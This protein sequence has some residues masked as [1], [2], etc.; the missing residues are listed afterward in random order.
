MLSLPDAE[1]FRLAGVTPRGPIASRSLRLF[2]RGRR[3]PDAGKDRDQAQHQIS[4]RCRFRAIITLFL[5]AV[6][7]IIEF[8]V[9]GLGIC[10]CRLLVYLRPDPPGTDAETVYTD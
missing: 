5:Y 2:D 7:V 3:Y 1:D 9:T 4:D 6:A 10:V 8:P